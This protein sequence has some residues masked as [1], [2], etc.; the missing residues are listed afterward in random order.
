MAM[1]TANGDLPGLYGGT[2]DTTTC[3]AELMFNY[4][5]QNPNKANAWAS[6]HRIKPNQIRGLGHR[7]HPGVAAHRHPRHRSRVYRS[8]TSDSATGSVAGGDSRDGG[9]VRLA[10]CAVHL[11]QPVAGPRCHYGASRTAR[12]QRRRATRGGRRTPARDLRRT[13]VAALRPGDDRRHQARH[14]DHRVLPAVGFP[15][16]C[17]AR[18]THRH[19]HSRHREPLRSATGK[20]RSCEPAAASRG[21]ET[22]RTPAVAATAG[23]TAG[24]AGATIART[25]ST[26]A[27]GA[28]TGPCACPGSCAGGPCAAAAQWSAADQR[29]RAGTAASTNRIRPSS[30]RIRRSTSRIRRSTGPTPRCPAG[31]PKVWFR[32][33]RCLAAA[34]PSIPSMTARASTSRRSPTH[35]RTRRTRACRRHQRLEAAVPEH[36]QAVAGATRGPV[37]GTTRAPSTTRRPSKFRRT[38]GRADTPNRTT[39]ACRARSDT[40]GDPGGNLQCDALLNPC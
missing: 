37:A 34:C 19:P 5:D 9:Q 2:L 28:R 27:A 21:R 7:T 6:V 26:G 17:T 15:K 8:R 12:G 35:V 40:G 20:D 36:P 16:G 13:A 38:P 31:I 1:R 30:I 32:N 23:R 18:P 14:P 4:L 24:T 11:R 39:G 3:D 22:S 10:T 25:G 33:S 29:L